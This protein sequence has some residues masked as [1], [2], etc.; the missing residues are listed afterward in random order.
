MVMRWSRAIYVDFSLDMRM[1]TFLR[2]HQ[3]ALAFF[4]GV[5]KAALAPP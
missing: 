2:M 3:R 1:D 5:P 4:G